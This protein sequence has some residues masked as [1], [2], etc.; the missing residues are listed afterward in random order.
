MPQS[1]I[2]GAIVEEN[3]KSLGSGNARAD[4]SCGSRQRKADRAYRKKPVANNRGRGQ[5]DNTNSWELPRWSFVK[6]E[7]QQQ[8]SAG[9]PAEEAQEEEQEQE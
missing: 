4:R 5:H 3:G 2:V 1:S 8:T 9:D 7:T 6:K